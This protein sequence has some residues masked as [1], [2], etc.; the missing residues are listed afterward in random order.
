MSEPEMK[1][2]LEAV[3]L[4][5]NSLQLEWGAPGK[6]IAR[7]TELLQRE[8]FSF[9]EK[10]PREWLLFLGFADSGV[11]LSPSLDFWRRFTGIFVQ[12]LCLTPDLEKLRH[13]VQVPVADEELNA[14][15][16]SA[17]AMVG[18]EYLSPEVLKIF[19]NSL[20]AAF[21]QS[22]TSFAGSI[23][24]FIHQY[25][26]NSNLL[27]RV[28]FHLVENRDGDY[29]FAF[30]A[31][32]STVMGGSGRSRHLP[33]KY[34]LQEYRDDR[35][36]LLELL[37]TVYRAARES[38][39]ISDLLE[40]NELFS[41][42]AWS[43]KEAYTFLQEVALYED[44][45]I[46]CRIPDWWKSR[47]TGL[48]VRI[49]L[50]DQQ[51]AMVG[52]DA[53]LDFSPHL[54]LGEDEI[55][56]QEARRLLDQVEGLAFIKNKWVEVD[57]EKLQQSLAAYEEACKL[58]QDDGFSLAEAMRLQ[59]RAG[60][61]LLADCGDDILEVEHGQWLQSLF[62]GLANPSRLPKVDLDKSFRAE[63]RPYQYDGL[64]W[65]CR[66]HSLGFG[67]CLADDMGL[68]KTVQVL[69]FLH[70]LTREHPGPPSLLVIPA[71]LL[72][73]WQQE[74]VRFSPNLRVFFA[75]PSMQTPHRVH[76]MDSDIAAEY[77]LIITTYALVTRYTWLEDIDWWYVILD[78]AQAIKN[79]NTRQTK[80]VKRLSAENRI[81]MTGTPVENRLT[82]F[83]SLND[84]VNPGLLGTAGEFKAFSRELA[85]H[86]DGYG[87][88][89]RM[90]GPFI[91]RRLKSDK[92]IIADL[93]DKVELKTWADLSR[94]QAVI[95]QNLVNDISMMLD[96]AKGMQRKGMI[97][98]ALTKFKQICNHPDQYTGMDA[99]AEKESGKFARLREICLTIHEKREQVLVFTQFKEM[100]APLAR[101]LETIF[102]RPGLV[103]HGSVAVG[104][105]KKIIEQFQTARYIPFM[106]LSLKA[107][108]VGLN[109]TRA[110]HV[111]HFDRWW[112]PAV[113][114][115]ATDRAFRIGQ[116]KKVMVHKF[117][118]RGTIEEKI[119]GMLE[120]KKQLARDVI[121]SGGETWLTEM[122]NNALRDLFSLSR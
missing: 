101:F 36:K 51:P 15:L 109:L 50:G 12:H 3:L 69:A 48:K 7:T 70:I 79:P 78:E 2:L 85:D 33:L 4:P 81:V 119:D 64:R 26:P 80:A 92:T 121:A 122:D 16:D 46:L 61:G 82:D 18:G 67:A 76:P 98:A 84:F 75:H 59:L 30:L 104:K 99:Y 53:L 65:L 52:M 115:Q 88:L 118:S 66:L 45:G 17:P 14:L 57:R 90:T 54:M 8:I 60:K 86:P 21:S 105:R 25:S 55:S 42:L 13:Q 77:D 71:S 47:Q 83:W 20:N 112:N 106:V 44:A 111:I 114:D 110:N 31:T 117:I 97:L 37:S 6:R 96:D 116:N 24:E 63:L 94:K 19:W 11:A 58:A 56:P 41:P 74:I 32:Y 68:G 5:D 100:T 35:D 9:Y 23:A 28:Y 29:P 89:R 113:E 43:S 40:N 39:L 95:Y 22:I 91:L 73:N 103:L 62:A 87:R 72:A 93:P 34:A 38:K 49:S 120:A 102:G 27:G 10:Q 1:T 108:G 107:G